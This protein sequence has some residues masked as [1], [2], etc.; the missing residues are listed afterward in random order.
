MMRRNLPIALALLLATAACGPAEVVVTVEA[1]ME[2]PDGEGMVTRPLADVEVQ[3][4][5]YDRDAV[6]DSMSTAFGTP[7][8]P[9]PQELIAAR[10]EVAAA[11]ERWQA[12]ERRWNN[13]RDTL[14]KITTAMDQFNRGEARYRVLF[15]EFQD[16]ES[17]LGRVERAN[18]QAFE[19]FTRL[20]Q[21]TI[22]QSDSVRIMRENWGDEAFAGVSEVFLAKARAAGLMGVADTTDASGVARDNFKVKPGQ[23]WVYARYSLPYTE[24]YWN[25]PITVERGDPI[26]IR[27]DRSNAQERIKL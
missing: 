23:Y 26:Q 2:N 21:A 12:A 13:L 25:V 19:E 11:Q 14:Q 7:E 15:L 16:F 3:L 20:Q 10:E 22:R 24:L 18:S 4:L 9:I 27:L 6:F 1:E 5:P 8:P 17:Q